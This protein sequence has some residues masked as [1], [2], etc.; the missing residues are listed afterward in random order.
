MADAGAADEARNPA[1]AFCTWGMQVSQR[2][3]AGTRMRHVGGAPPCA[4]KLDAC[5]AAE[6][7]AR[8]RGGRGGAHLHSSFKLP[9]LIVGPAMTSGDCSAEELMAAW[10]ARASGWD[11]WLVNCSHVAAGG[12]CREHTLALISAGHGGAVT[13]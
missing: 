9:A 8:T 5:A 3:H 4:C 7:S 6:A 12:G 10:A 2:T 1:A 13:V 11:A